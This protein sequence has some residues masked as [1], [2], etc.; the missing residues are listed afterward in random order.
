MSDRVD[1]IVT[2]KEQTDILHARSAGREVARQLG[3]GTVDQTRLATAISEMARNALN[4]GKGGTCTIVT[5]KGQDGRLTIRVLVEDHG[6]GIADVALALK[7]G[8]SSG[9]GLG[10][11]LPAVRRLMDHLEIDSQPGRTT[12]VATMSRRP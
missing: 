3:F 2:I 1:A 7:P 11:G 4:Y 6:P 9:G 10:Q 5:E 12:V 8:F